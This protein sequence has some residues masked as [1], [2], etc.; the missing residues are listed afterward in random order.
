MEIDFLKINN[1]M[2]QST[3]QKIEKTPDNALGAVSKSFAD[4]LK[5]G[6]DWANETSQASKK[7]TTMFALGQIENVHDVTIAAEK[8]S[9]A[10]KTVTAVRKKV[11]DAYRDITSTRL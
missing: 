8:A 10:M 3:A 2:I 1:Q 5:D 6:V 9:L 7:A 4:Y 11:L